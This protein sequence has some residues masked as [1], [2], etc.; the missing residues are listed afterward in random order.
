MLSETTPEPPIRV[1]GKRVHN[2]LRRLPLLCELTLLLLL[3]L[4][5]LLPQFLL[6]PLP[7]LLLRKFLWPMRPT[8]SDLGVAKAPQ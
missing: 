8:W 7:L 6:L 5:L 2:A 1:K 4:I 3:E